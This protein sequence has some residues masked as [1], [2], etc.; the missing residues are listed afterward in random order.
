MARV[1]LTGTP[2]TEAASSPRP[3]RSRRLDSRIA[4]AGDDDDDGNAAHGRAAIELIESA[5]TPGEETRRL[6]GEEDQQ[7]RCRRLQGH[8]RGRAREDESSRRRPAPPAR[9]STRAAAS[10]PPTKA[11]PPEAQT[12]RAMPKAV[13]TVTA[14]YAAAGDRQR[15]RR[16]QGVARQVTG[17]GRRPHPRR[18]RR[19][20]PPPRAAA[21]NRAGCHGRWGHPRRGRAC[22]SRP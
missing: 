6:L 18:G 13:T 21:G 8:R 22:R 12:G 20:C 17:T 2:S 15:V 19:G 5:R 16:R 10:R 7:R 9:P 1:D 11:T 3:S 14:K 4:R